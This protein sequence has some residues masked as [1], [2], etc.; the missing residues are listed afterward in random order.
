MKAGGTILCLRGGALGDFL[1]TRPALRRLRRGFPQAKII[2]A[3]VPKFA[4][5]ARREGLVDEVWRLDHAGLA[6]FFGRGTPLSEEWVARFQSC[7]VVISWLFDPLGLFAKNLASVGISGLLQG[8]HKPEENGVHA[9]EQLAR[10]LEQLALFAEEGED[11][12]GLR[13]AD[14][15]GSAEIQSPQPVAEGPFTLAVHP[16]S[17]GLGKL[18]PWRRWQEL[19]LRWSARHP[20]HRVVL[21]TGEAEEER[22]LGDLPLAEAVSALRAEIPGLDWCHSPALP[23]LARKMRSWEAF[24][25]HDTGPS[26]LAA[27]VGL[28]TLALFGPTDPAVWAPQGASVLQAPGGRMEALEVGVVLEG[29]ETIGIGAL[30]KISHLDEI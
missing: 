4:D 16:G 22:G 29:V 20:H 6:P 7:P 8:C 12:V 28:P 10:V 11:E 24:V 23:E 3:G 5:L 1:L 21:L 19:I 26:H 9:S 18:W 30:G 14:A 13:L 27:A 15:E 25:G 17:G 2:L